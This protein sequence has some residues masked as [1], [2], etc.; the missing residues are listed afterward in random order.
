MEDKLDEWTQ[1]LRKAGCCV[2]GF[3]LKVKAI[4]ILILI[5]RTIAVVQ[6]HPSDE[7]DSFDPDRQ[8]IFEEEDRVK[9]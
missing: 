1:E 4:Q 7:F 3:T 6:A 9:I 8:E 5:T 2:S